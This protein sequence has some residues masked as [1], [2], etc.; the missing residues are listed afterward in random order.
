MF[1]LSSLGHHQVV[2]NYRG[3]YT[4]YGMMQYL[5]I[6]II[7]IHR[8]L[9]L[10]IKASKN[11]FFFLSTLSNVKIVKFVTKTWL[12]YFRLNY[13]TLLLCGPSSSVGI[14][15]ELRAGRSGIEFR[16][17]RDFSSVQTGPGAHPASCKRS[18]GSFPG[19]KCGRGVLL[20]T[21]PL[22]VPPSWKSRAIP[23][24]TLWAT[25]GL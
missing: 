24:P 13:S 14:A 17:G 15:T 9:V 19:V 1:R 18:T 5:N 23:L 3:N 12:L 11:V 25:P 16:W 6:K 8:D 2:S 7:M 4:I 10:S 20:T 22:L 21:Y